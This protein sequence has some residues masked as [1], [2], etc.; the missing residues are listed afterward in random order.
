[1]KRLLVLLILGTSV[2]SC[3]K[4][5]CEDFNLSHPVVSWHLFPSR[6]G[7]IIFTNDSINETFLQTEE[8]IDQ[9]EEFRCHMC[10]CSRDFKSTY[11]SNDNTLSGIVFYSEY[12][13]DYNLGNIYFN[14]NGKAINFSIDENN[15]IIGKESNGTPFNKQI[16]FAQF[17]TKEI[18]GSNY[19]DVLEV[20]INVQNNVNQFWVVKGIGL[21]AYE[22]ANSTWV[23]N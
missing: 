13:E 2:N 9:Y 19:S 7:T 5:K 14:I 3:K 4:I 16:E 18:D 21:M 12:E 8:D 23:R 10:T 20:K 17:D 15:N 11:T 1:M 6:V 22:T